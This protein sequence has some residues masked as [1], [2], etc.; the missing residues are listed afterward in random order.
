[1]CYRLP[2]RRSSG[3]YSRNGKVRKAVCDTNVYISALITPGKQAEKAWLLAVGGQWEVYTSVAILTEIAGKLRGKFRWEDE[4]IRR[5]LRHIARVARVIKLNIRLA[6]LKDDPDNRILECAKHASA[7][8]I[9]TGD[10]HLLALSS[11][12]GIQIMTLADFLE[13]MGSII[14]F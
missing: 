12:E 3:L 8:V 11:F 6:I 13:K 5:A 1:M 10:H 14:V 2:K 7:E 9:V 4:W